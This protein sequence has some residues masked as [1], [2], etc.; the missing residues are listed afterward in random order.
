L[1]PSNLQALKVL[2]KS[3]PKSKFSGKNNEMNFE[4]FLARMERAMEVEGVTDELRVEHIENW[5]SGQALRII[6]SKKDNDYFVDA[7][8]TLE[9]IK[10]VLKK[11][12]IEK[13][14]AEEMLKKL[15]KGKPIAKCSLEESGMSVRFGQGKG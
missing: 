15:A 2:E 1:T 14:D 7:T 9:S 10:R 11:K 13:F 5:F 6:Q 3:A 8:T 4:R 12:Y